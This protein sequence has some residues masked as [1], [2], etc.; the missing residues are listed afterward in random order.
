MS[1]SPSTSLAM[2]PCIVNDMIGTQDWEC[3]EAVLKVIDHND[4]DYVQVFSSRSTSLAMVAS[5]CTL[6]FVLSST[7]GFLYSVVLYLVRFALEKEA[8][9]SSGAI[10]VYSQ[11]IE[12][13]TLGSNYLIRTDA[14]N[15]LKVI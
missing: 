5:T 14:L 4:S 10:V 11:S 9:L 8:I 13:S 6:T 3:L 2:K 1:L 15:S 7:K 12:S